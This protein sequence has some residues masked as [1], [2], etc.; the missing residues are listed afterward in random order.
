MSIRTALVAEGDGADIELDI[1]DAVLWSADDPNLYEARISLLDGDAVLDRRT[2]RF[3]IRSLEWGTDGLF[4]NG[5]SRRHA[6][7]RLTG[8]H[9]G[10]RGSIKRIK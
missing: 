6:D 1:P 5:E 9:A 3:G 8:A 7:G 4:V 2:E 10:K